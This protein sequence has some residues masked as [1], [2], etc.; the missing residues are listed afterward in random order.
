MGLFEQARN[1]T[2]TD[3]RI[4][5]QESSDPS[6]AMRRH[7]LSLEESHRQLKSSLNTL[8]RQRAWLENS[9]ERKLTLAEEWDKRAATAALG[10]RDDLARHALLRKKELLQSMAED[11]RQL[12]QVLPQLSDVQARQNEVHGKILKARAVRSK[13]FEEGA[14]SAAGGEDEQRPPQAP[15]GAARI[16]EKLSDRERQ[17]LEKELE[18]LKRRLD[19]DTQP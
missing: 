3:L 4:I 8:E 12:E 9:A 7:I 2:D 1:I 10:A 18:D 14:A 15:R 6:E 17:D 16:A 5:V 13:F 19:L 11:R